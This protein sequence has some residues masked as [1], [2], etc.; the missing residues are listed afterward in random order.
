MQGRSYNR[1]ISVV[2]LGFVLRVVSAGLMLSAI[3]AS[4]GIREMADG[5]TTAVLASLAGEA[6]VFFLVLGGV[7]ILITFWLE[8]REPR[9]SSG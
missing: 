4:R 5:Q 7:M 2:F 9:D 1:A 6:G 3:N 8:Q